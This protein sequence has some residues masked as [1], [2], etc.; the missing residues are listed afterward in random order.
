MHVRVAEG[1]EQ[2]LCHEEIEALSRRMMTNDLQYRHRRQYLRRPPSCS[3][4]LPCSH[5]KITQ[6][7][8]VDSS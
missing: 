5:C 2:L 3:R 7:L 1:M 6:Q 8:H 4:K